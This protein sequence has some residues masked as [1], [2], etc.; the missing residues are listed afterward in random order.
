MQTYLTQSAAFLQQAQ[1]AAAPAP[2]RRALSLGTTS[3]ET[4]LEDLSS[5]TS[6][7]DM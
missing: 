5:Q 7:A 2:A 1:G 6:S 3:S 4:P